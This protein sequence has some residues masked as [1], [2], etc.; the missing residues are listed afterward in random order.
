MNISESFYDE[1]EGFMA[2]QL[3]FT[4]YENEALHAYRQKLN[5]AESSED[6]RKF[7]LYTTQTLFRD[8]FG[9]RLPVEAED[10]TLIPEAKPYYRF[11]DRI[12][13]T[14][15][16]DT[17]WRQSDLPRVVNRFAESAAS[18]MKHLEKHPEKTDLKIRN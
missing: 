8:I 9:G 12:L 5:S 2:K 18:R 16:F 13:T 10:I 14:E 17:T 6:V 11:A 4:K 15:L 7:F 3:S 1:S